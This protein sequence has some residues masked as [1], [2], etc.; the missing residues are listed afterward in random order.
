MSYDL[1]VFDPELA[2]RK[3]EI[4]VWHTDIMEADESDGAFDP[5][6]LKSNRL[7]A[8]YEDMRV[9]FPAMN[10][11]DQVDE[12]DVDDDQ[13]TGYAFYPGFIYMD[14][15]WSASEPA[16][17]CWLW[18]TSMEWACSTLRIRTTACCRWEVGPADRTPKPPGGHVC[19]GGER[20]SSRKPRSGYPGRFAELVGGSGRRLASRTEC[21][22]H[23]AVC[24]W[25]GSR[26]SPAD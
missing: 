4:G 23:T 12:A 3:A 24:V 2:P 26:F 25:P 11:P 5:A 20:L 9:T 17:T 10:G 21:S 13:V 14:F 22:D 15:R 1:M 19:S 18:L 6:S 16:S 7:R 8:F